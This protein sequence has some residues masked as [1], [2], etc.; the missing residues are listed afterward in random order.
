MLL[1]V[2]FE[3]WL[4]ICQIGEGSK[5]DEMSEDNPRSPQLLN[6][7]VAN[8]LIQ[9]PRRSRLAANF[10]G[11]MRTKSADTDLDWRKKE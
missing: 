6:S 5:K 2:Y 11:R 8:Q 1:P 9:E 7:F 3:L 4:D 10:F